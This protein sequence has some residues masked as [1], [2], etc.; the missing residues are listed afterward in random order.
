MKERLAVYLA[1]E[2]YLPA[3]AVRLGL[4]SAARNAEST[5]TPH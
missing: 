4:A 2:T 5:A 1:F 3:E